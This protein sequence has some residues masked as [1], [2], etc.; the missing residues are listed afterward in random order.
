MCQTIPACYEK[1]KSSVLVNL[2]E[3]MCDYLSRNPGVGDE[4]IKN[5]ISQLCLKKNFKV[6]DLLDFFKKDLEKGKKLINDSKKSKAVHK[7]QKMYCNDYKRILSAYGL[8]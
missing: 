3:D 5:F 4:D 2:R 1:G 8:L 7:I 6:M